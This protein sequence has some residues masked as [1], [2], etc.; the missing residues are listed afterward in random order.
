M[1][2]RRK[3]LEG[4]SLSVSKGF[5]GYP[6]G[7]IPVVFSLSAPV[8]T[9]EERLFFQEA[10]PFGFILFN[11][12]GARNIEN[13]VQLRK[14]TASLR[15]CVGWHC[16]IL[17]DQEGGRVQRLRPPH[18]R[19]YPAALS[20]GERA[21]EYLDDA[22]QALRF[23]CVQMIE[24]LQQVGVNVNCTPVLDLLVEGAHD[25]IGDRAFG[26]DPELVAM[27]GAAVAHAYLDYGMTPIIKHI[28]GHGR[29]AADSHLELPVV[30]TPLA[31][32]KETDFRAF[33]RFCRDKASKA[34]WAM[35]AHVIYSAVDADKPATISKDVIT[36]IIRDDIGFEGIL[37]GDDLDMLAL[38]PFGDIAERAVLTLEAGCDLALHCSGNLSDMRKI[39]EK[40]LK[41]SEDTRKRLQFAADL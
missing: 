37:I 22:L 34:V 15:E 21:E 6:E 28:P 20:F 8:L 1:R 4:V 40:D 36:Q 27:M 16:P 35:S 13:P 10:K 25:I 12:E 18:W 26:S 17:I 19:D 5:T 41:I 31:E 14:L 33:R 38:E 39:A 9:D 24:D 23:H 30:D 32:L 29:A 2:S 11:K 3:I 7:T